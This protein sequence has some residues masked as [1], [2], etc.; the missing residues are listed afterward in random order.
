MLVGEKGRGDEYGICADE[1]YSLLE[2]AE[3]F[4]GEVEI[5]PA[6]KTSRSSEAIDS[7]KI[8]ALGWKQ[9][10]TLAGY[11]KEITEK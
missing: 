3:M 8:K 9:K 2:L 4:G 6:T 10:R 7:A 11:I 1:T 5:L